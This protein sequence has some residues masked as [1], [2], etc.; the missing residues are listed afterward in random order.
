LHVVRAGSS[1]VAPVPRPG[2]SFNV[3]SRS[4]NPC[5]Q[6][7]NAQTTHPLL[8]PAESRGS[9]SLE[10]SCKLTEVSSNARNE[11]DETHPQP[12]DCP[13]DGAP[14]FLLH[15]Q[16]EENVDQPRV[17]KQW[18]DEPPPLI[19]LDNLVFFGLG[20]GVD[21]DACV[22]AARVHETCRLCAQLRCESI[23]KHQK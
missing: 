23:T 20:Q 19:R 4:K 14:K 15:V 10:F 12:P 16:D 22:R 1:Y 21:G 18:C 7:C 11:V 8:F 3:T 2:V 5:I 17:H 13:L 6:N 9:R